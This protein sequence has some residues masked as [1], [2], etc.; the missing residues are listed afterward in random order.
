MMDAPETVMVHLEC[1]KCTMTAT[2]VN[3]W[4]A[5]DLWAKHMDTHDD[6]T[7]YHTWSW[8]AVQL[9]FMPSE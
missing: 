4:A 3:T 1:K 9:P 6:V 7:A 8:I 5:H 2:C